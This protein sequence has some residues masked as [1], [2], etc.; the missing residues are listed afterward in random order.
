M[1]TA[2]KEP[3][4]EVC[5]YKQKQHDLDNR[6]EDVAGVE[7]YP[8]IPTL[9]DDID[10]PQDTSP[11]S[12]LQKLLITTERLAQKTELA[13]QKWQLIA[14]V[15]IMLLIP[16]FALSIWSY[17]E[18][19]SVRTSQANL[20][21]TNQ[22][23]TVDL[24]TAKTEVTDMTRR[25]DLLT[26][27]NIDL[28]TENFRL[29]DQSQNQQISR[30]I[31]FRAESPTSNLAVLEPVENQPRAI[32]PLKIETAVVQLEQDRLNAI[33]RGSYPRDMTSTELVAVLGQPDRTYNSGVFK[34]LLY[35]DKKP[36]RFW[37]NSASQLYATR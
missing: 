2:V 1:K 22:G 27:Q 24:Q 21:I 37:F 17:V 19:V 4:Q 18:S 8:S 12:L 13:R 36:G 14:L 6:I 9:D 15:L 7:I 28:V 33:R 11:E 20:L 29:K 32:E 25:V 31:P 10:I 34:Q 26:V 30:S 5:D 3:P 35:F 23:L 16:V